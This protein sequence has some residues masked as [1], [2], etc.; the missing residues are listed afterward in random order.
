VRRINATCVEFATSIAGQTL[1]ILNGE[2]HL[3]QKPTPWNGLAETKQSRVC[4]SDVACSSFTVDGVDV[5]EMAM[6][7]GRQLDAIGA[8]S[9]TGRR[10][11]AMGLNGNSFPASGFGPPGD[12][13]NDDLNCDLDFFAKK[14]DNGVGK[15]SNFGVACNTKK[16]VS[17]V[18]NMELDAAN[19]AG[20]TWNGFWNTYG[21]EWQYANPLQ[22]GANHRLVLKSSGGNHYNARTKKQSL[23]AQVVANGDPFDCA[24]IVCHYEAL[25]SDVDL[26]NEPF[27]CAGFSNQCSAGCASQSCNSGADWH[28]RVGLHGSQR[29]GAVNGYY[30][31]VDRLNIWFQNTYQRQYDV[32]CVLECGVQGIGNHAVNGAINHQ[33]F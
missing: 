3:E 5:E 15:Q 16:H 7:A 25:Q 28:N 8:S 10:R 4:A 18:S 33:P 31:G 29:T 2:A 9:S 21:E 11:L 23:Q 13:I 17:Y 6:E 26:I 32:C 14:V 12:S 20:E 30:D 19:S 24:G 1:V 22:S 27:D